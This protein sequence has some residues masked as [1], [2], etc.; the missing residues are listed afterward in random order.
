MI[1][2]TKLFTQRAAYALAALGL[3]AAAPAQ[4][5][6]TTNAAAPEAAEAPVEANKPVL[7]DGDEK[8]QELFAEWEKLDRND[9]GVAPAKVSVSIPSRMPLDGAQLTSSYGMRDHP[10]LRKRARHTGVDLAAPTGTPIY[11][12]ADG[13]V[14]MAE[15]F[16]SYG[17]FIKIGHG[18]QLETRYAHLSRIAV[19]EGDMVKKGDLIGYVGSTGRSTGPHL[20]YEV[21]IAGEAVNPI[22]YMVESEAQ[23]AFAKETGR[24]LAVG[25]D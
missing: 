20:H 23:I 21:R 14:Q 6:T 2:H 24:N 15:W 8:F 11:A 10:I 5:T 13:Y 22:P 25:G 12:T 9:P 16:S 19:S 7:G 17:K 4:A 18:N 1:V 3:F